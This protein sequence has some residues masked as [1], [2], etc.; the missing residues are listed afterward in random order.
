MADAA[1]M[2]HG[3]QPFLVRIT[4]H[5]DVVLA[6]MVVC[7]IAILVLPLPPRFLDFLLAF[8]ITLSL[9]VL[10][11]TMYITRPLEL[12]VFPGMLLILTLALNLKEF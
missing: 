2:I 1:D 12:S 4:R 9:V 7:I 8:N 10:L 11:V 3:R 5:S 6:V